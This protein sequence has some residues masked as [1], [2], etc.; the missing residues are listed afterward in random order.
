MAI[1]KQVAEEMAQDWQWQEKILDPVNALGVTQLAHSGIQLLIRI[2][3]QPGDQW[4][5]EREFCRRLTN[6][7]EQ[8]GIALG[9]PQRQI[10]SA[11]PTQG[12]VID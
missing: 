6:A 2:K 10:I 7:F 11:P 12:K 9:V 5:V 3:T 8:E 1:I 4:E